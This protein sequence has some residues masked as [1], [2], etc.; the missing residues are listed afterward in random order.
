M[1]DDLTPSEWLSRLSQKIADRAPLLALWDRYYDGDHDLPVGPAQHSE[2]FRRFQAKAR[3]NLCAMPVE[4]VVDRLRVNGITD[5][6]DGAALDQTLFSWWQANRMD[7]RQSTLY[8]YALRHG[9]AFLIVGAHPSRPKVPR[10]TVESARSVAVEVD[11]ADPMVRRAAVRLWLDELAKTWNATLWLPG[12]RYSFRMKSSGI[13]G[14]GAPSG[15]SS[16]EQVGQP[17]KSPKS[18]PVIPFSNGDELTDGVAEFAKGI[19]IQDRLNLSILNRLSAERYAA[20][21]QRWVSNLDLEEDENGDAVQPFVPGVTELWVAGSP[22]IGGS[23][24]KFGDFAQTDT[25]QMLHGVSSDI[26]AFMAVTGTPV[27]YMPGDL[28]NIGADTIAA[29]DAGHLSKC[30][31]RQVLWGEAYEEGL[32]VSAEIVG[33]EGDLSFSEVQWE[34]PENWHPTQVADLVSKQVGA[35]IPLPVVMEDMGKSP[36]YVTRL[37]QEM[38]GDQARRVI[39]G[40]AAAP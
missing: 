25:T 20:Y 36:Q 1:A 37:R 2:A 3:M 31:Q 22:D 7:A 17:A 24:V 28:T 18:I 5:G 14:E 12:A 21:R 4:S 34:R 26:K 35:G 10:W 39:G 9:V 19:D 33:V 40:R 16:W 11:P 29:L 8:R 38:A 13:S 15:P 23:E 30:R 6:S 27:Y 32:A